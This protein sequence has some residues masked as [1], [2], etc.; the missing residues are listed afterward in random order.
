MTSATLRAMSQDHDQGS[1]R[2]G[3]NA[4][5]EEFPH[6]NG[7]PLTDAPSGPCVLVVGAGPTGLTTAYELARR[8]LRVRLIDRA[9]GPYDGSDG[10][11]RA[12]TLEILDR[13]GLGGTSA[14]CRGPDDVRHLLRAALARLNVS[15]SWGT[16]LTA[17][18]QDRRGTVRATLRCPDGR[19]EHLTPTW[20]VGCDGSR[21]TVR[22]HLEA[23]PRE[24]RVLLA[25]AAARPTGAGGTAR[26]E[27]G[28]DTGIQD[29]Y[30][31][32]WKLAMVEQGHAGRRLLAS[33]DDERMP[34]T[35]VG[36]PGT[37]LRR[38]VSR[39][40]SREPRSYRTSPL[41][42]P[43]SLDFV[44]AY[45]AVGAAGP[46]PVPWPGPGDWVG[47]ACPHG[48]L[49]PGCVSW[50]DE[51]R[52][53]RW[54][55]LLAF[56][57]SDP[58]DAVPRASWLSVRTLTPASS[59]LN[60]GARESNRTHPVRDAGRG[61]LAD[62]GGTVRRA[63]GLPAAGWLLVRPDGHVTARGPHFD[64]A[65]L[66]DALTVLDLPRTGDIACG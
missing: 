28:P 37:R 36:P 2:D 64:G 48:P 33:Y 52:D 50:R 54:T 17:V 22:G 29:A 19:A 3:G 41:T 56:G 47:A 20:L 43:H 4:P 58:T 39:R 21:S 13:M 65:V 16:E 61:R 7:A 53:P 44:P 45:G 26:R 1:D 57:T 35:D 32:A 15:V 27:V 23:P 8:N 46:Q 51:L 30:N 40:S 6:G 12:R 25:G 55:L 31:L 14:P 42:R 66:D 24:G 49:H 38:F 5:T 18:T 59:D 9:P 63:L 62:P 11:L 60:A 34:P 10:I